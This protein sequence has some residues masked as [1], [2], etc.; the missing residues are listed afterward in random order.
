M[1]F[2][3]QRF[4]IVF[5]IGAVIIYGALIISFA[6]KIPRGCWF[7]LTGLALNFAQKFTILDIANNQLVEI[8]DSQIF[9]FFEALAYF[10]AASLLLSQHR[11][12]VSQFQE[13]VSHQL[14]ELQIQEQSEKE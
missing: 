3:L 14:Q 11:R 13:R 6:P 7:L 12:V 5:A 9:P 4:S 10:I 2:L 1:E 8:L